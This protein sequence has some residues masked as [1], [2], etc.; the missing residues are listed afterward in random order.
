MFKDTASE[1]F[2]DNW[3]L[4]T[5]SMNMSEID[6]GAIPQGGLT[7]QLPHAWNAMGWNYEICPPG[8][9]AGVGWYFK[10][11]PARKNISLKFEGIAAASE[12]FL[13]GC[14]IEENLGAHRVF[15]V[16]LDKIRGDG[17][18]LLAIKVTDKPSVP[19]LPE[20]DDSFSLSPRYKRW[21]LPLG[22]S[23]AAGG[24]WRNVWLYRNDGPRM[25]TPVVESHLSSL[26]I[27][28]KMAAAAGETTLRYELYDPNGNRVIQKEARPNETV[29]LRPET[30]DLWWPLGP[31]LYRLETTLMKN[32]KT[33]QTITQATAFFE[34]CLRNSEIYV[35][36]RPYFLRGQNGFPHCNVPHDRKYIQRYVSRVCEQGVEISRFHTEPPSHAWLDECDRQGVMVIF[37]MAL[38]GSM[39]CYPLGHPQF[40]KTYVEEL[41]SLVKEYRRHPSIV[42][43]CLG[44]EIIVDSERRLGL[45]K[46]FFDI[47]DTW[48]HEVRQL[49]S[50][51][52]IANS[53]GDAAELVQKTVGDVDDIHQYGGWYTETLRDL[54]NYE[55]YIRKNDFLFSPTICTESVAAYTDNDGKFFIQHGDVRQQKVVRQRWGDPS[56]IT[57]TDCMALQAFILK[58]YAEA[59]W[60]M[61]RD[62]TTIGGYIPFGQYTWFFDPFDKGPNGLREKPIWQTYRKVLSPV[63]VQLECWNR[64]LFQGQ[65]MAGRLLLNHEDRKLPETAEFTII[66]ASSQHEFYRRTETVNYHSRFYSEVEFDVSKYE[67]GSHR[68]MIRVFHNGRCIAENNRDIKIYPTG[69]FTSDRTIWIYDPAQKLASLAS[70][71]QNVQLLS[72]FTTMKYVKSK[73][74][75]IIGPYA[76][77]RQVE[78]F[79][80]VIRVWC[81][82][83]NSCL[84]ME[85]LPGEQTKNMLQTGI[86]VKRSTQPHWSRWAANMVRH[87][88]RAD[89]CDISHAVFAGITQEDLSWWND[90]TFLAHAYLRIDSTVSKFKILSGIGHGLADDELMPVKH[91][92]QEQSYNPLIIECPCGR[93][94]ILFSNLLIGTKLTSEPIAQILLANIVSLPPPQ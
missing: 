88:D 38:H 87:A 6:P 82:K 18:D 71:L 44:N 35:N 70:D 83:G 60:R 75:L 68:L 36:G 54:H 8:E 93:G 69:Y 61:R 2:N 20:A 30:I 50:R 23:L 57:P 41:R 55:K 62:D 84:V 92:D 73:G 94:T 80:P 72:D 11:L 34:I 47:V 12:V 65:K 19:L 52:V 9:P 74:L 85:Q 27:H 28:T 17:T 49:D 48:V 31:K 77:D 45:G 4:I 76:M 3:L 53:G 64:H 81:A 14:R 25:Q 22:S 90:D 15:E 16:S 42:M 29:E 39:G 58:E 13:N 66:I 91:N 51:P 5:P 89:I 86:G 59:F 79:T 40:Q 1:L 67:P 21:A 32:G 46:D 24:I 7:V 43:W 26:R 37:E 78:L 56:K 33:I 63:H 10:I